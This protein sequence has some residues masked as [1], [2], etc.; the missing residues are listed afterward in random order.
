MRLSFRLA[1]ARPGLAL[2]PDDAA[3]E[4]P[5][6][7]TQQVR[8]WTAAPWIDLPGAGCI[9]GPL[10]NRS[11][12]PGRV[13]EFS[14]AE[15]RAIVATRGKALLDRYWGGYIALLIGDDGSLSVIRDPS[16]MMPC[17]VKRGEGV[18]SLA[19][20]MTALAKPG[21]VSIDQDAIAR[22]FA[23]IDT[24]GRRAGIA[25]IEEL[26]PGERLLV[27]SS[28]SRI[29]QAWSPW[30][31]VHPFKGRDFDAAATA[32]R[33]ALK[34][35]IGAWSTCFGPILVGVSGGLDSSIVAASLRPRTPQL[36]CLTMVEPG[37]DGDERRYVDALIDK[38][39]VRLDAAVYDIDAVDVTRAVFPHFPLPYAAHY[40]Q[41]IAAEHRRIEGDNPISAY[42]SGNG[43]DNVFCSLS[44]GAP[45]ADR[46]LARG[47]GPG[48]MATL[49]DLADITGSGLT[50]VAREGWARLRRR[51]G[52]H[53]V[54]RDLSGLGPTGIAA[55]VTG[56]DTHPWL[57]APTGTLPGKAAH[58]A[59]LARAQKSIELYPR[60]ETAP[61]IAP[62]LS[63][64]VVE[65]C[66]SIPS[67]QWVRGGRDRSVARAAFAGILPELLLER[68]TKGSPSGFIRRVYEAQGESARVLLTNG[69]LVEAG[70][71][72]PGWIERAA[73]DDWQDDGRDLRILSFAA[74]EAW[75]RW[76][77]GERNGAG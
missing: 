34:D 43:G 42:F 49:R 38:L 4:P 21:G 52:G 77:T 44:S 35:C 36:R 8:L 28:G 45:L 33:V 69:K 56:E 71:V 59:M 6:F 58:V 41:A 23:G 68:T 9:V 18:V 72:D 70:L 61:Q 62:L 5:V 16:G 19:S 47:P 10:F 13:T 17:Y 57:T 67:W 60:V 1:L 3:S 55:A 27:T 14:E 40:F 11:S 12:P 74:A 31:H 24:I 39:G 26:L 46:W 65:L 48:S 20:D 50:A 22:M 32:L 25:G 7:G 66:L 29:E 37:T 64:P 73:A 75:V 15:S 53:R 2:P 76:W 54:R 63:Q 30:D 51:G